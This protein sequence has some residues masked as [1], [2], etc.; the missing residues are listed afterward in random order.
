MSEWIEWQGGACPVE[1]RQRVR[2]KLGNGMV[3]QP[4]L[5]KGR[6]WRRYDGSMKLYQ[7]IAYQLVDEAP[8]PRKGH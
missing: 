4:A 1:P 8:T 2:C 3:M 7:I 5:A 6:D